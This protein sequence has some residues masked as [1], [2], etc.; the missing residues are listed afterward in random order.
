MSQTVDHSSGMCV[1][2]QP[3][4]VEAASL[5]H[6]SPAFYGWRMTV[7]TLNGQRERILVKM[8]AA[9]SI[10]FPAMF[11]CVTALYVFPPSVLMSTP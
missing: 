4:E 6:L 8:L 11:R 3:G 2:T 7:S 1:E 10:C 9:S 5:R